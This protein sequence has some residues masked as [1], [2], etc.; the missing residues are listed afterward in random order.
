MARSAI[1]GRKGHRR[2]DPSGH[3]LSQDYLKPENHRVSSFTVSRE[4]ESVAIQR[5]VVSG[6]Y[7]PGY[8]TIRLDISGLE[9]EPQTIAI[10]AGR[11]LEST[12]VD[13][14]CSVVIDAGGPFVLRL[15]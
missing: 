14:V 5:E 11:V 3:G 1:R 4:D 12:W 6:Q 7:D 8:K 13:G 10:D 9:A 2:T 15:S